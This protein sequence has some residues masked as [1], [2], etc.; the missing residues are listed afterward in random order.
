MSSPKRKHEPANAAAAYTA[1]ERADAERLAWAALRARDPRLPERPASPAQRAAQLRVLAATLA[2]SFDYDDAEAVLAESLAADHTQADTHALKVGM[3]QQAGDLDGAEAHARA[4]VAAVPNSPLAAKLLIDALFDKGLNAAVR[5]EADALTQ[6]QPNNPHAHLVRADTLARLG[7]DLEAAAAYAAV[8]ERAPG[9]LAQVLVRQGDMMMNAGDATAAIACYARARA[10]APGDAKAVYGQIN[11]LYALGRA[12][13]GDTLAAQAYGSL[14]DFAAS[15]FDCWAPLSTGL[16]AQAPGVPLDR[17]RAILVNGLGELPGLPLGMSLIKGYV[18]TNSDFRVTNL[19]LSASYFKD[20]FASMRAGTASVAF[21]EQDKLFAAIDLFTPGNPAYYDE[22][23]YRKL[24]PYFFKYASLFADRPRALCQRA[25]DGLAPMPWFVRAYAEQIVAA[26]PF[27][28]GLSV[29]FTAQHYFSILLA[30]EIKRLDPAIVTVFGGGFFKAKSI[31]PFLAADWVDYLVLHDGE[32]A[33]L[34]LLEAVNGQR[35]IRTVPNI[36]F[37]DVDAGA[38]FHNDEGPGVKQNDLAYANYADY[39]FSAYFLPAP[40]V[41]MLTSRGCYWRR[42]TF[43]D[44]FASY[45]GTYKTQSIERVVDELEYHVNTY[46]VRHFSFVDEM[47]SAR[48][49]LKLS[50]EILAR[51]LDVTYY[52]LAKPTNDFDEDIL[53]IMHKA[54]CRAIYWGVEAGSDRVLELMDK[55]NDVAGTSR[56]LKAAFAAGIRNHLFMIVG[57]PTETLDELKETIRFLHD[58]RNEI[59][60]II[61]SPFMMMKG[62]PAADRYWDFGIAKAERI[63]ALCDHKPLDYVI[64]ADT[65]TQEQAK[66]YSDNLVYSFF[67]HFT[68]RGIYFGTIR[69][70]IIVCY[71]GDGWQGG[72]DGTER[73]VPAPETVFKTLDQRTGNRRIASDETSDK[74]FPRWP[75]SK[76][77]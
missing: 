65:I 46:G 22:E 3:A 29:T 53:A 24:A 12:A 47:I 64:T 26:R 13:E 58:H 41:P 73:Y 52:A 1:G 44:H 43:C 54:G 8:G 51:G 42:C 57:Y 74:V 33:F 15:W 66:L 11:A 34:N 23:S 36:A 16:K 38:V 63:R 49:F 59:Q 72:G 70:Q 27:V 55:G 21:D 69:D 75:R 14:P 30:K 31:E 77:T 35:D 39:D 17:T 48:R 61:P 76:T 2:N 6:A 4:A 68:T 20:L 9:A 50:E 28:V 7:R 71:G 25:L 10:M 67:D 37:F 18:E 32:V 62:T 56:T 40:V 45:A 5:T 19:D 60:K